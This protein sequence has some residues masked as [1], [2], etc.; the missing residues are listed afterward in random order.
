MNRDAS[1]GGFLVA[2]PHCGIRKVDAAKRLWALRGLILAAR[3]G[4]MT[5]VGCTECVNQRAWK[6]LLVNLAAGRWSFPWG[7]ATPLVVLEEL[8]QISLPSPV[9]AIEDALR[10]AGLDPDDVRLDSRGFTGEQRRMLD[11]AYAVLGRAI[12]ADGRIHQREVELACAIISHLTERRIPRDEIV[13]A[14]LLADPEVIAYE[15][16]TPAYRL[17]L[18]QMAV[19]VAQSDGLVSPDEGKFLRLLARMLGIGDAALDDLL[20]RAEARHSPSAGRGA[21]PPELARALAC[22]ELSDAT[23]VLAIKAAYR[24]MMLRYHPDRAAGDERRQA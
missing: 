19:D 18:L 13:D 4:T 2:C 9:Q 22:L 6:E 1:P 17:A 23:D 7:L 11:A 16:L 10:R 8:A 15:R 3:Y 21:N 5:L 14:L 12:L 24:R 20:R